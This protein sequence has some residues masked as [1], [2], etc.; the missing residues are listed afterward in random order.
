[1][2]SRGTTG[3]YNRDN[4]GTSATLQPN[5]VHVKALSITAI[6]KT[7]LAASNAHHLYISTPAPVL[8]LLC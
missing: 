2:S 3:K 8:N 5:I 7:L 6:H 4:P 1:M